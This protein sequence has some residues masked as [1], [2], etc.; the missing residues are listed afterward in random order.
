MKMLS[1]F[2]GVG[3]IDLAASWAGIETVA[4][5][6]IEPYAVS[7]LERRFENVPI[8]NDVRTLTKERLRQDGI[9]DIDIICGGWP[10]QD[11]SNAKQC[12]SE[13]QQ[14]LNGARSGLYWEFWRLVS[15]IRPK[16]VIGENVPA[17]TSVN[18]GSDW[19]AILGSLAEIGYDAEW[20]NLFAS[21]SGAPHHRERL[22]LVAYPNGKRLPPI[23]DRLRNAQKKSIEKVG[24]EFAGATLSVG[25][26]WASTSEPI[27]VANGVAHRVDRLRCLGNGC[28][29]QQVYPIFKLIMEAENE[30]RTL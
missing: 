9:T 22:F 21:R 6:E 17:I 5:C 23:F 4:L 15:D 28:V 10:C 24:R 12:G 3:M 8:Y 14:G 2:S 29:P 26:Y 1:L 19:A 27:R 16:F 18:G 11:N 30:N 7:V 13:R 25:D 20:I